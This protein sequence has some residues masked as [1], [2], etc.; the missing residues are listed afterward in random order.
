MPFSCS[1]R[2]AAFSCG[3]D[4]EMLGSLMMF[5]SGDFASAPSSASASGSC[6][7]AGSRSA[8]DATIRPAR[9]MSRLSTSTSAAAANART[10]GRSEC[11]AS[12]GASSV[13]V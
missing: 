11:V 3:T 1:S 13:Y 10:I 4:A 5:A 8:N 12:I 6:W 9:E 7:S 2:T